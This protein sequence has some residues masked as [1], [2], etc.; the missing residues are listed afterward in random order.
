MV[1]V[2]L[3]SGFN[4]TTTYHL[5]PKLIPYQIY[6][7]KHVIQQSVRNS[8]ILNSLCI[9]PLYYFQQSVSN[10][11][12][13]PAALKRVKV[14]C[15]AYCWITFSSILVKSFLKNQ[16]I[17]SGLQD[18]AYVLKQ[19]SEAFLGLRVISQKSYFMIKRSL[20]FN[21]QQCPQSAKTSIVFGTHVTT[22]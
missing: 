15:V 18:A 11:E 16:N 6:I 14:K 17:A 4:Q 10:S 8:G 22:Q 9:T 3:L 12:Q 21:L 2:S 20:Y 19:L 7:I 1:V 13:G 5:N